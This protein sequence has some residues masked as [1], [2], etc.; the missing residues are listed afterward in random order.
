V[1]YRAIN[2]GS[3]LR[4]VWMRFIFEHLND[5]PCFIAR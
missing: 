2:H 1:F 4:C 5:Y 3:E